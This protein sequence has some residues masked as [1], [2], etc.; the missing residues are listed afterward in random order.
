MQY[1]KALLVHNALSGRVDR[2]LSDMEYHGL[3][4]GLALQNGADAAS[5]RLEATS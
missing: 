2:L 5:A 1:H 4:V 3:T